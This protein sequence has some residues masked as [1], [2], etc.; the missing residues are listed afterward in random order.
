VPVQPVAP[1]AEFPEAVRKALAVVDALD[2]NRRLFVLVDALACAGNSSSTD[3]LLT[4]ML[5][6]LSAAGKLM[7]YYNRV[8]IQR[9]ELAAMGAG[10]LGTQFWCTMPPALRF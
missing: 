9:Q 5:V 2:R 4:G 8:E 6:E 3:A 7:T 10:Y 1:E